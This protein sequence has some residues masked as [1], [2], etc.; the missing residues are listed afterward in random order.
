MK[1]KPI[2]IDF[3]KWCKL[4]DAVGVPPETS[5]NNVIEHIKIK[6]EMLIKYRKKVFNK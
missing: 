5:V 2:I 3:E 1:S 4:C 6:K